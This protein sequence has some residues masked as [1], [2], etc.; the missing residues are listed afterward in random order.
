MKQVPCHEEI[1]PSCRQQWTIIHLRAALTNRHVQ[2][3]FFI[4]SVSDCLIESA[5]RGL[6]F[7][8]SRE[9]NGL[10]GMRSRQQ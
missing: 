6:R 9:G 8:I 3:V 1:N 4:R 10:L 5:M 2:A 7:P